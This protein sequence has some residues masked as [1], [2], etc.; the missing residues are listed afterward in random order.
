MIYYTE[1]IIMWYDQ[2]SNMKDELF[3]QA[4]KV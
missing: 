4:A 2:V 3:D 1:N